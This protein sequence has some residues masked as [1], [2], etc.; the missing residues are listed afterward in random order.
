M[1]KK[2]RYD[3]VINWFRVNMPIAETELRHENPYQLMVA[4][5]LSAQCTDKRVNLITPA[6]YERFPSVQSLAA[7]KQEDVLELIRSCSY[8]N[9]KAGHLIKASRKIL[10][11]F[12]GTIPEEVDTL[13]TIPGIGRKTANVIASVAFNKQALAV[14]THV[15]RV[16]ARLGLTGNART[17]L[18]TE[19]QLTAHISPELHSIAHHWLIL[20]GRYV[21][22]ARKPHCSEC[23]LKDFCLYF[24]KQPK[25]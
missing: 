3:R 4:V 5:I 6:F 11:D 7:A 22:I 25:D 10:G 14:D 23:G 1:K 15:H 13:M 8:P 2:E 18:E 24:S 17:P 16:S 21:C 19:K 20:H 12:G 9:N